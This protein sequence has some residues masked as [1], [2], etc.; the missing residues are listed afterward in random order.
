MVTTTTGVAIVK[1]E[2]LKLPHR[3]DSLPRTVSVNIRV[4]RA[5]LSLNPN[6]V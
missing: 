3:L 1:T 6:S 4:G 5:F 2:R